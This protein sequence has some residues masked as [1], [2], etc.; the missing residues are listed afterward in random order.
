M[1]RPRCVVDRI[2]DR[3]GQT[4]GGLNTTLACLE[5]YSDT[6]LRTMPGVNDLVRAAIGAVYTGVVR[7]HDDD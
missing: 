6:Y 7:P 3:V 5:I 4:Q 2:K 1:T